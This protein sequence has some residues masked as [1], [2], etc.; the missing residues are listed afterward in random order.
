[1]CS[2]SRQ[3]I[4]AHYYVNMKGKAK[5]LEVSWVIEI[6]FGEKFSFLRKF[7]EVLQEINLIMMTFWE[8]RY[9]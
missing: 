9:F 2:D 4:R 5:L 1:M 7:G 3:D 8:I 6:E